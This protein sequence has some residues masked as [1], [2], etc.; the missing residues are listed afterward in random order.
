ML[1]DVKPPKIIGKSPEINR[2]RK[3]IKLL[4]NQSGHVL[5]LGEPGS[6]R[7]MAAGSIHLSGMRKDKPFLTLPCSAVGDAMEPKTAFHQV[8]QYSPQEGTLFLKNIDKLHRNHQ[9]QL[10]HALIV[11]P[12]PKPRII[13]SA[14]PDVLQKSRDKQFHADLYH[15]LNEF[16]VVIPPLRERRQ[17]ILFI[18][19][20]FLEEFCR[21]FSRSIPSVPGVISDAMLEY[22]W[23][24]NVTELKNCVR[25]LAMMSPEDKLSPE[26]LPF[27]VQPDPLE[28]LA[29]QTLEAATEKVEKFLIRRAL[30]RC[31]N[32]QSKA[33]DMLGLSE[34]VMRYKMKKYGFPTAR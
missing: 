5:I 17:D 8:E 29:D 27:S 16:Q 22:D 19:D 31:N 7:S 15:L 6:G 28:I 10:Y 20:A 4:A 1:S 13:A 14:E 23:P 24:G 2:V 32:N 9:A 33:A 30:A 18:F 34:A 11:P 26:F 3:A 21:E 12:P 25:N